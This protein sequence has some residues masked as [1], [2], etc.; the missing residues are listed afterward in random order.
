MRGSPAWREKEDLLCSVPSV[1][2]VIS[3]TLIADLPEL[4]NLDRKEIAALVGLAPFTRQSGQWRCS[5]AARADVR[6]YVLDPSSL[7]RDLACRSR[8]LD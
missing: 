5:R 8:F 7:G 6:E 1:G 3:R 4:G 2:R